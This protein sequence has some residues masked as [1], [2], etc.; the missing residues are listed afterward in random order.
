MRLGVALVLSL[1]SAVA[2]NW[3]YLAQHGAARELPP[4]S[5]RAPIRSLR[6][7]FGDLSWLAGFL[8]GLLGWVFYIGALALA[9]LSLV[10]GVSAGGIAVL[11]ALAHRRGDHLS[12]F[13]WG[14]IAVAA[15]GLGLLALSLSG[16]ATNAHGTHVAAVGVWLVVLAGV[17]ALA[18]SSGL[19]LAAGASLGVA[20]GMLYGAGDIATKAAT[21][22]GAWACLVVAM[23]AAHGL[24]FVALQLGFQRGGPIA[25][26]GTATLLTNALPIAAGIFLFHEHL[27]GGALG[28]V[29]AGGFVLV[30]AAA[31]VL[32]R[33]EAPVTPA[34]EAPLRAPRAL[35]HV[36]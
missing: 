5:L 9:P 19:Q 33:A 36:P 7:L 21:F 3:G 25:T 22:G 24:A 10:Q 23:L 1:L 18:S 15:A 14:A 11:A 2:L 16:G 4:L 12:R 13:Q 29:R 6:S 30:V 17:A 27:P 28:V 32:A 31:A 26:A 35:Q 20:A 34:R 8:V